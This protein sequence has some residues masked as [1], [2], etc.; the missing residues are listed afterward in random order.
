VTPTTEEYIQALISGGVPEMYAHIFAGFAA[1]F[2][3]GE[4]DQVGSDIFKLTC[5]KPHSVA[6][7]LKEVYSA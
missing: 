7:F 2:G 5:E 3:Q 4:F 6:Q 1:A